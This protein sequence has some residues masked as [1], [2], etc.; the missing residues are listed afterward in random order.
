MEDDRSYYA[1]RAEDEFRA[2]AS[3]PDDAT[4][5]LHLQLAEMMRV[6]ARLQPARTDAFFSR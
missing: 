3:A 2:A 4:R 1:R 5:R 6:R